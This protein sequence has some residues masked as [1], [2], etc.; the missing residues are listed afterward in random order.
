MNDPSADFRLSFRSNLIG[1][2]LTDPTSTSVLVTSEWL[3]SSQLRKHCATGILQRDRPI[4]LLADRTLQLVAAISTC[5][6]FSVP[7]L[8]VDRRASLQ[9]VEQIVDEFNLQCA[10]D[11]AQDTLLFLRE[12]GAA[13]YLPQ[14]MYLV[15]SSGTSNIRKCSVVS[16]KAFSALNRKVKAYF[17]SNHVLISHLSIVNRVEFGYFL[18]D[19]LLLVFY[20]PAS[21]L[22]GTAHATIGAGGNA[23]SDSAV[24]M[25]PTMLCHVLARNG[26][27]HLARTIFLSG[28]RISRLHVREI[29][30]HKLLH[31]HN[32]FSSYA[33]TE[34]G[35]Q[36]AMIKLTPSNLTEGVAGSLLEGV[37][38]RVEKASHGRAGK[39]LIK[40]DTVAHGVLTRAGVSPFASGEFLL[41]EDIAEWDDQT[42]VLR[43]DG[44]ALARPKRNGVIVDLEAL[45]QRISASL[46]CED[47]TVE[48][49]SH[50]DTDIVVVT[51][52]VRDASQLDQSSDAI[53]NA[54]YEDSASDLLIINRE[55]NLSPNGKLDSPFTVAQRMAVHASGPLEF[56][57]W[58][59]ALL[60]WMGFAIK[61]DLETAGLMDVGMKSVQ[62][63]TFRDALCVLFRRSVSLTDLFRCS[64]L[65]SVAD[66]VSRSADSR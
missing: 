65:A 29:N 54:L 64:T 25:T 52:Y 16:Y 56:E 14:S 20:A 10:Y 38:V 61:S 22:Q 15:L 63:A 28:E 3:Y 58:T 43:I 24:S 33:L 42:G 5:I 40:T 26:P 9:E 4:A 47:V 49:F 60:E 19:L 13:I 6:D 53:P 7:F 34:T 35:G 31:T 21:T 48:L 32:V 37:E 36:I 62:L 46:D 57:R 41:T 1:K 44:R 55:W 8:I 17:E 59:A 45:Q 23:V 18:W 39:L 11:T 50:L 12:H 66:L 2:Y 51:L 27:T 30:R